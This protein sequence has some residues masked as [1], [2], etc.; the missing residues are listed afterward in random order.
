[1]ENKLWRM[2][3]L[4]GIMISAFSLAGCGGG[5]DDDHTAPAGLEQASGDGSGGEGLGGGTVASEGSVVL[6]ADFD[7]TLIANATTT[8]PLVISQA[9][10]NPVKSAEITNASSRTITGTLVPIQEGTSSGLVTFSQGTAVSVRARN[11]WGESARDMTITVLQPISFTQGEQA[12]EEVLPS[13]GAYNVVYTTRAGVRE[14]ITV[15]FSAPSEGRSVSVKMNDEPA[16]GMGPTAFLGL[17]DSTAP[18]WQQKAHLSF[19]VLGELAQAVALSGQTVTA[20]EANEVAL[21]NTI[22]APGGIGHVAFVGDQVT[23][24]GESSPVVGS[25]TLV[26]T[27]VSNDADITNG[28]SLQWRFDNDWENQS[29]AVVNAIT[30]GLMD[31]ASFIL[32]SPTDSEGLLTGFQ[33]TDGSRP[34]VLFTNFEQ[35]VVVETTPGVFVGNPGRV[36]VMDGGFDIL[37]R[38]RP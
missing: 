9:G 35:S 26:W 24:A 29:G 21:R 33:T 6:P 5:D 18:G 22:E 15:V 27:D 7:F 3:A 19:I 37:F 28:D 32:I 17:L 1:M 11:F 16:V 14:A 8:A 36:L 30:N 31:L 34:A 12:A 25:R 13:S 2:I 20:A 23:P 10:S 38:G 4:L